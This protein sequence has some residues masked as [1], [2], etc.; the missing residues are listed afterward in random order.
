MTAASDPAIDGREIVPD[1]AAAAEVAT[2]EPTA[3]GSRRSVL[4]LAGS[5]GGREPGGDG[6]APG[7]WHRAGAPGRARHARPVRRHRAGTG[8][9]LD[10]ADGRPQRRQPRAAVPHRAGRHRP[11]TCPGRRGAGLGAGRGWRGLRLPAGRCGLA[12][13]PGRPGAG[14][15]LGNERR[16]WRCSPSTATTATC[17]SPSAPA[18]SSSAWPGST[19]WRPPRVSPR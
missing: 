4:F 16:S 14:G 11:G 7:G 17:R 2:G 9:L 10:R 13:G 15:R 19:S 5:P 18:A 3:G 12:A 1:A 8:L 6:D